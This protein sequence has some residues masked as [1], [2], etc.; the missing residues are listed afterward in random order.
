MRRL[1]NQSFSPDFVLDVGASSG[2]W[3]HTAGMIFRHTRF[4]LV[5]PLMSRYEQQAKDY[6]LKNTP[7]PTFIECAVSNENGQTVFQISPDL[8]GS[9]LL[10]PA[11]FRT[12]ESINVSIRTLD[13]IADKENLLGRGLLKIDVQCA[14]HLVLQGAKRIIN[15]IDAIV[16][17]LSFVR[18]DP[19]ALIFSEMLD[20]LKEMGFRYYDETGDWRSPIDGTL[21][22]KEI[23]FV[24]NDLFIPE[25]SQAY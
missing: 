12:Y 13:D 10:N 6:Y 15:Q 11:D 23:V 3:S 17:E 20:L 19:N 8:Y 25:T 7:N 4:I 2:I 16:I 21:L 9:S 14:E 5:D 24:R 18:Y 1:H 22:Q